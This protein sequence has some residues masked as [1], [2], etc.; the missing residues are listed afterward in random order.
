MPTFML[1]MK[2]TDQGIRTIKDAPKRVQAARE[3]GKKLGIEI[4]QVYLTA[5]E[6]D[7]VAFL[8]TQ[9]GDN[10]AK[11]ALAL[12]SMGNVHTRTGRAWTETE[13]L[14]IVSELP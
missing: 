7:L 14:K 11:F 6:S 3:L 5:G 1:S 4:K 10:I 9:N 12:S 8:E 2:F 13:F